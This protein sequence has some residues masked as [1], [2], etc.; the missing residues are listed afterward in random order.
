MG[1][2]RALR[3]SRLPEVWARAGRHDSGPEFV[4]ILGD[5]TPYD[6]AGIVIADVQ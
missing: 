4:R 2:S 1:Q 3:A 5:H 6:A